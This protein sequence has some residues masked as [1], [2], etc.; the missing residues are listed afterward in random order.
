MDK[1]YRNDTQES[2]TGF[3]DIYICIER[4]RERLER[5]CEIKPVQVNFER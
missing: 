1:D 2:L 4:E 5:Q 3:L